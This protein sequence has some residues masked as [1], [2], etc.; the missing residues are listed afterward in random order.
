MSLPLPLTDR[1]AFMAG[2][3]AIV[4]GAA[5][6]GAG[7]DTT[8]SAAVLRRRALDQFGRAGAGRKRLD[9]LAAQGILSGVVAIAIGGEIVVQEAYG[10]ANR[11]SRLRNT[12]DTRFNVASMG[13]MFTA[14]AIARLAEQ[15]RLAW[16]DPVSRHVKDLPEAFSEITVDHLLS[17]RSGLGSYF[18]SPLYAAKLARKG[19][20]IEDYMEA[21]VEDRPKFA[22]GSAFSYSNNG[23]VLLGAVIE[24]VTRRDYFSQV[25][26]LVYAR[27]GM[28]H[29]SH[30]ALDQLRP[31][32]ARG[33]TNGCF[34]RPPAQCAARPMEEVVDGGLRGTPAGGV[35]SNAPDLLRFAQALQSG[36]IVRPSTLELMVQRH[37]DSTPPGAPIDG[38]GYGFGLLNIGGFATFGHNGGTPGAA[39][40]LDMLDKPN[41]AMLVLSNADSGQR[42]ASSVVRRATLIGA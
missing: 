14:L 28:R 41:V 27:A 13:K 39:G 8:E 7:S 26:D 22:P 23:Y 19:R 10:M 29:T 4:S 38:Y 16:K 6:T 37:V 31:G 21:V 9:E 32:D 34:A 1:R 20:T 24:A 5:L 12:F 25:R 17:H 2:S 18:A 11:S 33:Y 35:Y 15:G 42:P 30:T 36:K 3:L 40:Q